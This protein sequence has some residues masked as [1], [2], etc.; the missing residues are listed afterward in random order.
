MPKAEYVVHWRVLWTDDK[1]F[2]QM[3]RGDLL[4]HFDDQ[5]LVVVERRQRPSEREQVLW[6][7]VTLKRLRDSV[8]TALYATMTEP[9]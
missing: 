7:I 1:Y 2:F 8:L 6:A 9:S 5:L 3:R 4:I